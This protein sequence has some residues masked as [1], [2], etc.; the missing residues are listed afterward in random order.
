M[1]KRGKFIVLEGLDGSGKDTQLKLLYERLIAD[2]V[3]AVLTAEPTDFECGRML[4]RALSG[5]LDASPAELAALFLTD[6]VKHNC[7]PDVGIRALLEKGQTVICGRYYYSSFAYQGIDTDINWVIDMN[8]NC[9]DIIK[10]DLCIFLDLSPENC[11]E[12]IEKGRDKTE[13]YEKV[14]TL[15]RVRIRFYDVFKLLN[16]KENIKIVDAFGTVDQVFTRVYDAAK[17]IF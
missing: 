2:G 1:N 3:D 5:E 14:E 8:L 9:P 13:I 16:G 7:A 4:R 6:R 10:P 15:R 11:R 12:R 17:S